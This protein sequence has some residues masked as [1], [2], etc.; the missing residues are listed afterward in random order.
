M[1]CLVDV[2]YGEFAGPNCVAAG[3]LSW[4]SGPQS[5]AKRLVSDTAVWA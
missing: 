3:Y 5:H 2:L 4:R 1:N